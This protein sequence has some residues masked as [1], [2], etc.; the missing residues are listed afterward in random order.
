M[1]LVTET[2][3]AQRTKI[4]RAELVADLRKRDGDRCQY[5][6]CNEIIDFLITE[7][8]RE[9]TIDHWYPQYAGKADGW[10]SEEIWD[11][12]NLKLMHKKCNAKKGDRIPNED[13]T[14]PEK[15]TKT[16][17]YRR[18]KRASRPDLC[19]ACDNGHNLFAD[20]ICGS[21]GC[22]AQRFP[23]SAKVRYDECDHEIMWCWACSIT[24]EMRP[25]SIG[26]AMRHADS[27]ELGE[28]I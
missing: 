15:A 26:T 11:L 23:R 16:F 14:L 28:S 5:P 10:T 17:R 27:D 3:E 7:G 13:G 21:C 6:D 1:T 18:D 8:P 24:P 22:N 19:V 4:P 2:S 12:S 9:N 20:E 25:S